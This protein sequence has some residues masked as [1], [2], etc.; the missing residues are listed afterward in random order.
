MRAVGAY[1]MVGGT[2]WKTLKVGGT[3]KS[4]GETKI[5]RREQAGQGVSALK[6]G[7]GAGTPLRA[8]LFMH[9]IFCL[10]VLKKNP[11][12]QNRRVI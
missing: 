3:E 10:N 4:G 9:L 5:L 8:M 12:F 2:I 1:V 7:R 11:F 6:M